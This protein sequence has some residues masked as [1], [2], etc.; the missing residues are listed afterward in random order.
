MILLATGDYCK[1]FHWNPLDWKL[2]ETL[3]FR[4]QTIWK[5]QTHKPYKNVTEE[6]LEFQKDH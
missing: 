3:V 2:K 5:D 6:V 1:N 4:L